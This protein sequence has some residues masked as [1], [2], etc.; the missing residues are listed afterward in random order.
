[1]LSSVFAVLRNIPAL[2][3]VSDSVLQRIS[4]EGKTEKYK[5]GDFVFKQGDI[6]DFFYVIRTGKVDVIRKF[7][8]NIEQ[9]VAVL[10][11]DNFF[12]EMA[13]LSDNPRNASIKCLED[14]EF[15]VF[16]KNDFF[17]LLQRYNH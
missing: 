17:E 16:N 12:G 11:D 3:G 9:S 4:S 14:C 2:E 5:K 7:K 6:G 8:D 13:L 1:M 15:L 10:Y